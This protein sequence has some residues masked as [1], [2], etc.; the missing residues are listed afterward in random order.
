MNE[1][2]PIPVTPVGPAPDYLDPK[3][4]ECWNEIVE[5]CVDG[6]LTG[7]D[8]LSVE[9]AAKLLADFRYYYATMQSSEKSLLISILGKFGMTPSDRAKISVP[10]GDDKNPFEGLDD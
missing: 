7:M 8:R 1:D 3:E 5:N 9:V 10:K 4:V 2:E 6:V